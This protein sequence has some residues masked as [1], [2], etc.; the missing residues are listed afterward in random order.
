MRE[1]GYQD[2]VNCEQLRLLLRTT[3]PS[4]DALDGLNASEYAHLRE[5][6]GCMD[7]L[8]SLALEQKPAIEVPDDF[9]AGFVASLPEK[10]VRGGTTAARFSRTAAIAC[11]ILILLV[12]VGFVIA[13]PYQF[14]GQ[15]WTWLTFE[16]LI[17]CEAGGLAWWLGNQG[18]IR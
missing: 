13:A 6:D 10:P 4:P 12:L 8:V 2:D 5:C 7:V 16:T 15:S 14:A 18:R 11:L 3:R 17:A 1:D 9:A